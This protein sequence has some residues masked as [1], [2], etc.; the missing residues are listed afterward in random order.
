M[1]EPAVTDRATIA[2]HLAAFGSDKVRKLYQAWRSTITAID[3]EEQVLRW[4][5]DENYPEGPGLDRLKKLLEVLQPTEVA[6]RQALANAVAEEL[7]H[8]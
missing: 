1:P 5:C 3:T 7:V 4:I 2:A 8:R 6:A